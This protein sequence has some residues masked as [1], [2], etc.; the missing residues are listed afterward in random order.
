MEGKSGRP[1]DLLIL[2]GLILV[3][4]ILRFLS[5]DNRVQL[6]GGAASVVYY[7]IN[8][9]ISYVMQLTDLRETNLALLQDL[10]EARLEIQKLE[11]CGLENERLR[12]LLGF[13]ERKAQSLFPA[14]VI[15]RD[16]GRLYNN[17]LIDEG[18][19]EGMRPNLAVVAA[20]GVVGK[21]IETSPKTALVQTVIDPDFRASALVRR[22]RVVGILR[23]GDMGQ[24]VL[25]DVPVRSDVIEGD[26]V[27][28]S[29]LG[30][31][32][33]GALMLGT[34]TKVSEKKGALFQD[35]IVRP[36]ADVGRIEEVFVI[37][38]ENSG[39]GVRAEKPPQ[40]SRVPV[41]TYTVPSMR[42]EQSEEPVTPAQ[43]RR[44]EHELVTVG[45]E[46]SPAHMESGSSSV[47]LWDYTAPEYLHIFDTLTPP[48][49]TL[50]PIRYG[51]RHPI[52]PEAEI[53]PGEM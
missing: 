6:S 41:R 2:I 31:V 3:C 25:A 38:R 35:I 53:S 49:W 36:S 37:I 10:T 44:Y 52:L 22:T 47:S 34:V 17:L 45:P 1:L 33:P 42:L 7:P 32:F 27:I 21:I 46:V 5:A 51:D 18:T 4:L 9:V 14:E 29:G 39:S 16:P 15:G 19:H 43:V 30:G 12:Q 40:Q 24:C 50:P 13:R 11:E 28:T 23:G 20:D 48:S 8:K 26:T